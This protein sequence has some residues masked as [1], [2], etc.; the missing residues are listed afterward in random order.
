[1]KSTAS[2]K[3]RD[4]YEEIYTFIDKYALSMRDLAFLFLKAY[5]ISMLEASE[6]ILTH[7]VKKV[8]PLLRKKTTKL[9]RR[10]IKKASGGGFVGLTAL[11]KLDLEFPWMMNTESDQGKLAE[12]L[13]SR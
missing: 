4:L 11:E 1:V 8:I 3:R 6:E 9:M 2:Q 5:G 13:E 7:F 10:R 12:Y